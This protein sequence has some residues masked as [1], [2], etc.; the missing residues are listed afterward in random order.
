MKIIS[1]R[2]NI[3]IL[4]L[5]EKIKF[6]DP[7]PNTDR[8][9]ILDRALDAVINE[10]PDL[11]QINAINMDWVYAGEIKKV[12]NFFQVK[13]EESKIEIV[14]EMIKN[15]FSGLKVVR[16]PFLV[17]LALM[18]YYFE[19]IKNW[20]DG[21]TRVLVDSKPSVVNM[22]RIKKAIAALTLALAETEGQSIYFVLENVRKEIKQMLKG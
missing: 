18:Y 10:K 12:T 4:A 8:S 19:K 2:N 14:T 9:S 7:H 6:E 21:T 3:Q 17:K 15:S 5:Y 1:I 22:E 20:K 16:M 13:A 11:Q